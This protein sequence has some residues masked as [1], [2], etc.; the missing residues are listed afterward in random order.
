[1]FNVL[2]NPA[3]KLRNGWW[4]AIF[5]V[6][7]AA[8]LFPLILLSGQ[9]AGVPLWAQALIILFATVICQALRRKPLAEVTGALNT[10]WLIQLALGLAL[11]ALLM[12]APAFVLFAT[13]AVRWTMSDQGA[14]ALFPAATLMAAVAI[15][16]E[17]LFRG[18]IFQRFIDGL[19]QWWAQL[20]IGG[21][22]VL[23]HSTALEG[24]GALGYLA[25][26]NIFIASLMFGF[27]FIKTKSL[28]MPIGIHFAANF[29]QGGVLGFGVSGNDEQG[30]LTP[31]L[32]GPDW[33]TG[34]AFGLE[35][36]LP[37]LICVIAVTI[38]LARWRTQRT[39]RVPGSSQ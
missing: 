13:G 35:A 24:A 18:F 36:S 27:A 32:T 21:L 10:A 16:E 37:G 31:T 14:A 23:T 20:I 15:A 29:V 17:L 39:Q 28:A 1:M 7:L 34:A 3:G 19:G 30:L 2:K 12:L 9:Q 33:L 38:A 25:G 11:G 26:L 5:F 8:L 6:V 4:V 22:F